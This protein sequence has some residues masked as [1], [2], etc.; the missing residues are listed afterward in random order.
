M[1][2]QN[3]EPITIDQIVKQIARLSPGQRRQLLRWLQVSGLME[4]DERLTD[5]N[6]LGIAPAV[7]QAQTT[8]AGLAS[9]H[10]FVAAI[11]DQPGHPVEEEQAPA[12]ESL[13]DLENESEEGGVYHSPISGRVVVGLADAEEDRAPHEMSPLPGQAPEQ[14]IRVVFD[15]G[16]RGNPG[17]G[18]GSY[19]LYWPGFPKQVVQLKFGGL[20]TNN[21]AEYDTLIAAL[22][23]VLGRLQESGADP[24][25]ARI[26]VWGDSQLVVN[27]INGD[28]SVTDPRMRVRRDKALA[29]FEQ[30]GAWRLEH[31]PREQSVR[32]LGH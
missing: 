6:P 15:G 32:E 19:A 5:R 11:P 12:A 24:S 23:A 4:R 7:P 21:E 10:N 27:Q 1:P 28:W 13:P 31:H 9:T 3:H 30:F 25:T 18:Y 26:E 20:V 16:S 29:L 22:E 14:P 17:Q 2:E 8:T